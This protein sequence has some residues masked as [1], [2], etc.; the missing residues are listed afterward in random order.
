M[1][2]KV[3]LSL[4]LLVVVLVMAAAGIGSLRWKKRTDTLLDR[5]QAAQAV[6]P[7]QSYD[8]AILQDL[9]EPV[10]RYFRK[11]LEPGQPMISRVSVKHKGTFN[12][13][14]AGEQWKPFTSRQQVTVQRPGFVWN[15]RIAVMPGLAAWVHDAYVAG[16]GVLKVALLGL[17]TLVDMEPTPELARGELMRWCAEATWYPT[18]LLPGPG[19]AWREVDAHTARAD[20]AVD[21][22]K[23]RLEFH[24]TPDG[25]IDTV[26][27]DDRERL[28]GGKVVKAS[29]E[30]RFWNYARRGGMRV[31]LDGEV[32]WITA[33]GRKPYWRGRIESLDYTFSR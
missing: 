4:L 15:A 32:A 14:E 30:G 33:D 9:P 22:L 10:Q 29:W 2:W 24:F 8:P 25:L 11:V 27:A 18:A 28:L 31:P 23:V 20:F 1:W 26:R 13:K 6:V 12:M 17:I 16:E 3:M 5:L 7:S 21:G 19:L